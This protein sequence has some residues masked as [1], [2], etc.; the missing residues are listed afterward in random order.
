MGNGYHYD[1]LKLN[2]NIALSARSKLAL[3]NLITVHS[4]STFESLKRMGR[5]VGLLKS[6]IFMKF[7]F[8]CMH[9]ADDESEMYYAWKT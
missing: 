2:H 8:P 9:C 6:C 4:Q 5:K 7:P 3:E 1:L